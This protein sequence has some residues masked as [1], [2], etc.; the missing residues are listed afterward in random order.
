ME[1]IQV[2]NMNPEN[3]LNDEI[4]WIVAI[5]MINWINLKRLENGQSELF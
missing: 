5:E 4:Q 1:L 3:L 2:D